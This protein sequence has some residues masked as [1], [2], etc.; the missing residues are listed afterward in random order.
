LYEGTATGMSAAK[1]G[2]AAPNAEIAMTAKSVLF[3]FI[4]GSM[5]SWTERQLHEGDNWRKMPGENWLVS[6]PSMVIE[7]DDRTSPDFS[8]RT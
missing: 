5:W 2:P 3:M 4:S 1:A 8:R 6:Y 7:N